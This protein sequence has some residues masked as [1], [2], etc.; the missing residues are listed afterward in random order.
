MAIA[1]EL[2]ARLAEILNSH[3]V[4]VVAIGKLREIKAVDVADFVGLA[5]HAKDLGDFP[6]LLKLEDVSPDVAMRTKMQVRRIWSECRE[7]LHPTKST[8]FSAK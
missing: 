5:A 2:S 3:E 1:I 6:H 4:H 7:A 8:A